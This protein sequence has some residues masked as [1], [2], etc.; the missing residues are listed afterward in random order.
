MIAGLYREAARAHTVTQGQRRIARQE[1]IV[2]STLLGS[3][4]AA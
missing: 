2:L 1:D 3:C 4:V